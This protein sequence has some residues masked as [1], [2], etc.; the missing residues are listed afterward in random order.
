MTVYINDISVIAPGLIDKTI[1]RSILQG[2]KNWIYQEMPKLIPNML[3]AN[4]RRR[5]TPMI[6]LALACIQGLSSDYNDL[7]TTSTVFAS[8]DGDFEISDKICS[9]LSNDE[10]IISPTLFHN[11][12]HNS[13]AGYWSIASLIKGAST[14][15]S[16]G[17]ATFMSGLQEAVTQVEVDGGTVLYVAYEYPAPSSSPLDRYSHIKYPLAIA[18]RIGKQAENKALGTLTLEG[19][20]NNTKESVC[21]NPSLEP[22]RTAS[23]VGHGMPLIVALVRRARMQVIIPYLRDEKFRISI[24][25]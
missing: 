3:P 14:S 22:L 6:R 10:K 8:S 24:S 21:R 4:E 20:E 11:S 16:A 1:T 23:P 18:I 12:V 13:A 5:T 19:P 15:I 17:N 25:H 2:E 7:Q 9:A